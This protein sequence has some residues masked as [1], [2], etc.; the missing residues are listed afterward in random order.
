M[1]AL[2][3]PI[4]PCC[5][6]QGIALA[7]FY[8]SR[9]HD[10]GRSQRATSQQARKPLPSR[11]GIWLA[12]GLASILH[13]LRKNIGLTSATRQQRRYQALSKLYCHWNEPPIYLCQRHGVVFL[14][15]QRQGVSHARIRKLLESN[16]P[17]E[18]LRQVM[19]HG[20]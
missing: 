10:L 14:P 12:G 1:S 8:Q 4:C 6:S 17:V 7:D 13:R 19:H 2:P 5:G 11:S 15:G 18:Q 20:W 9:F 3:P 16:A